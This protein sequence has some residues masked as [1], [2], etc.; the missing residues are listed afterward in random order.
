MTVTAEPSLAVVVTTGWLL[1][2][3]EMTADEM[4]AA[5][6]TGQTVVVRSMTLVMTT[7][8]MAPLGRLAKALDTAAV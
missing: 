1:A 3:L 8:E 7:L 2:M 6:E 5:L 4:E